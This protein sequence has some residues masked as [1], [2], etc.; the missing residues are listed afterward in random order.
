MASAPHIDLDD[1]R[2]SASLLDLLPVDSGARRKG[3][4]WYACCSF[5]AEKTPS[6]VV[7]QDRR[8]CWRFHCFSCGADGDV[9]DYVMR[10]QRLAFK[11][12]VRTLGGGSV[13]YAPRPRPTGPVMVCAAR[14]CG[15]V[16][17]VQ[18]DAELYGSRRL[19]DGSPVAGWKV[20][21]DGRAWCPRC[22]RRAMLRGPRQERRAA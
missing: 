7:N 22:C 3:G 19:V 17:S 1:L 11:E 13:K 21:D 5:H 12:A 8:G 6:M 16:E 15:A 4:K 10:T 20:G 18:H 14:G 9:I 2:R